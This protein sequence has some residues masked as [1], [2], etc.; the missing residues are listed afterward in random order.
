MPDGPALLGDFLDGRASAE[1]AGGSH[2]RREGSGLCRYRRKGDEAGKCGN[3]DAHVG[4]HRAP[5]GRMHRDY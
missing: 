5:G 2:N 3:D 1:V 4:L